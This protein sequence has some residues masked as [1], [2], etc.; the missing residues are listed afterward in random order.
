MKVAQDVIGRK[1][2]RCVRDAGK[3]KWC[4]LDHATMVLKRAHVAIQL[5]LGL[6]WSDITEKVIAGV[7]SSGFQN[8]YHF[9]VP[10][11]K[12]RCTWRCL[13]TSRVFR[14]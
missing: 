4:I 14:L 13:G 3:G 9:P 2:K 5:Y 10:G 8:L 11:W 1:Q 12:Q 7:V 6:I